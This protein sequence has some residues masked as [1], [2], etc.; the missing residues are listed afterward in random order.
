MISLWCYEKAENRGTEEHC[1][2]TEQAYGAHAWGS[3]ALWGVFTPELSGLV[4]M[5]SGAVSLWVRDVCNGTAIK[6]GCGSEQHDQD[7]LEEV[8]LRTEH[9]W[10]KPTPPQPAARYCYNYIIIIVVC[11]L[12]VLPSPLEPTQGSVPSLHMLDF[13]PEW[14]PQQWENANSADSFQITQ[15][16][17]EKPNHPFSGEKKHLICDQWMSESSHVAFC[18]QIFFHLNILGDQASRDRTDSAKSPND[19]RLEQTT[20]IMRR[21][22]CHHAATSLWLKVWHNLHLCLYQQTAA[23]ESVSPACI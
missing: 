23:V 11:A 13:W 4:K 19:F 2:G 15:N 21:V 22:L 1:F 6:L 8:V 16:K 9:C 10:S 3:A 12:Y 20:A 14:L 17:I 5:D 18:W 7:L